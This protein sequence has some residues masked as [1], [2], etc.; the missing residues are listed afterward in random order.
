MADSGGSRRFL[1]ALRSGRV[2]LMDGAMGTELIRAGLKPEECGE[3]WNLTHPEK[4]RTV[5][6]AYVEAGAEVLLTNTFLA[7]PVALRRHGLGEKCEA[8]CRAAVEH[9]RAEA[10]PTRWVV[11]DIAPGPSIGDHPEEFQRFVAAL[12]VTKPDAI[13]VET[14][15]GSSELIRLLREFVRLNLTPPPLLASLAYLQNK[16]KQVETILGHSPEHAVTLLE[17]FGPAAVGVNCGRDIGMSQ[18][19]GVVRAY[20]EGIR[21]CVF[22]RP[23]AGTPTQIDDRWVYPHSPEYMASWLPELLQAGVAMIGG[24]CG[25]TPAHIAAFRPIIDAWNAQA[26]ASA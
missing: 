2:L 6:R 10:G 9:A 4:V 13:L 20:H 5:H 22:A 19:V 17:I 25:T 3:A 7:N 24:C 23:N 12:A 1:D 14:C 16:D 8:I 18:I 26:G 11:A 21:R 15:D